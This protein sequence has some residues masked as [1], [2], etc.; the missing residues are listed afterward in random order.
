MPNDREGALVGVAGS[1]NGG[2]RAIGRRPEI[3]GNPQNPAWDR[4]RGIGRPSEH[5]ERS[6]GHGER[7]PASSDRSSDRFSVESSRV[8]SDDVE[9]GEVES[10]ESRIR[11]SDGTGIPEISGRAS[12]ATR[13]P[14]SGRPGNHRAGV[15]GSVHVRIGPVHLR[16]I[17]VRIM[18]IMLNHV[19]RYRIF[20]GGRPVPRGRGLSSE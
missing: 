2:I 1:G 5:R 8:E 15:L 13:M 9:S 6:D 3:T 19:W 17:K 4:R 12:W 10:A 20:R 14:V 16:P 7:R 18:Y 11:R